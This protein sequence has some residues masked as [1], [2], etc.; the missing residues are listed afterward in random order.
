[1]TSLIDVA[2]ELGTE[3]QCLQYLESKRWPSGV[4]CLKCGSVRISRTKSSVKATG[5]GK[6][7]K[8]TVVKLRYLYDCLEPLCGFQFSATTGTIFHDSHLPLSTWFMAVALYCSAKK[9]LSALQLQRDLGIGSYRTAWYLGHRI[10]KAMEQGGGSPFSGTVEMDETFIGGQYDPRRKRQR[11]EK[12]PVF[13]VLQRGNDIR[14][15]EVRAFPVADVSKTTLVGAVRE[16]VSTDA[17]LVCTDENR[18][19]RWLDAEYKRAIVSHLKKEYAKHVDGKTISTNGIENFWSLF[20]RAL[21]GQFHKVS[22]KH[23]GRYLDESVY[24]FNGRSVKNLFD[25]TVARMAETAP[26]SWEELTR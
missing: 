21:V 16:N 15:S 19:Y 26:M 10:R 7:A 2:R 6:K 20:K 8:G 12:Q 14:P 23:L 9:S 3:E 25:A 17:E 5:R 11:W 18:A 13:G 22:V 24:K 4:A 1:M